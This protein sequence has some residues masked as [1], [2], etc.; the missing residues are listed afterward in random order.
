MQSEVVQ[1]SHCMLE[2]HGVLNHWLFPALVEY[3]FS[4]R[5]EFVVWKWASCR[6]HDALLCHHKRLSIAP[7]LTARMA[8]KDPGEGLEAPNAVGS[9]RP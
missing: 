7:S 3:V 9:T 4:Q 6:N 2:L 5:I 8:N 1:G